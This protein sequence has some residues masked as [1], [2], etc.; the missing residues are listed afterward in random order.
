M[1]KA[2]PVI[3]GLGVALPFATRGSENLP[4]LMFGQNLELPE[5]RQ[6]V[7]TPWYEYNW[8]KKYWKNGES[9]DIQRIPE[10]GFDRNNGMLSVQYALNERIGFD[11][12]FGYTSGAT[13][14]FD[15][16]RTAHTSIG[17][18]DTQ[19]G[20]RYQILLEDDH[21]PRPTLS[22]RLGGIIE[23][24]YDAD[25]PFAPG[26]G[27]SGVE[28]GIGS[29]KKLIDAGLGA[30]AWLGFRFRNH[31][32]PETFFASVGLNQVIVFNKW[33]DSVTMSFGYRGQEDIGGDDI[34]GTLWD[35]QYSR[36]VSEA[37]HGIEGGID[38]VL[39]N[40]WLFKYYMD[41]RFT[42]RNALDGTT[43]GLYL[44]IPLGGR[45]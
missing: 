2:L 12:T 31:D 41:Y 27:A 13:R 17:F 33:V 25:F 26:D 35:I 37:F 42:G 21:G 20:V 15:I 28:I 24:T 30:Y 11:L 16:G 7:L 38:A 6:W 29:K 44:S 10:D 34:Q 19:I 18:M 39:C 23:G 3:V 4:Y 14:F 45:K 1:N 36:R 8:A 32:V 9:V 22:V 43:Y 5:A 40:G